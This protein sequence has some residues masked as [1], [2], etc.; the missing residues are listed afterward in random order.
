MSGA[1]GSGAEKSGAEEGPVL[2]SVAGRAAHLVLN[3]PR[4]LNALTHEMVGLI[5]AA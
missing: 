1:Q 5:D 2:T 4:A 3:R